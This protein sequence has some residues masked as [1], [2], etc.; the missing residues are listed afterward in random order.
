MGDLGKVL[1]PGELRGVKSPVLGAQTVC[2]Y[3]GSLAPWKERNDVSRSRRLDWF[4]GSF[5]LARGAGRAGVE[6]QPWAR[7][8]RVLTGST[9]PFNSIL[10]KL[11][12]S[13]CPQGPIPREGTSL[14][15]SRPLAGLP[16]LC[17]PWQPPSGSEPPCVCR[18]ALPLC[19]PVCT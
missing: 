10:R 6:L 8:E 18:P 3:A 1:Q 9:C 7:K 16:A 14:K 19:G 15:A 11:K 4:R 12:M 13:T 17:P 2:C 5:S